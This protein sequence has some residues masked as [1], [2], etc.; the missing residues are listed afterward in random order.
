[1]LKRFFI[2]G[3]LGL[4]LEVAWTGLRSFVEGDLTFT[5]HSSVIMF[6]IY[7]S[8]VLI[9]PY[10]TELNERSIVLR[11][12][13]YMALIFAAEYFSGLFL[14]ALNMCPWSYI[15]SEFNVR[16]VVRLDY[17]P[18]WFGVGLMYEKLYKKLIS[19]NIK[20]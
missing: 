12:I 6:F 13:I 14:T 10:F 20:I 3:C 5:G 15:G 2:Y 7:G 18:L 19:N 1:M 11:G 9:E 8:V 16:G 17:M 4:S